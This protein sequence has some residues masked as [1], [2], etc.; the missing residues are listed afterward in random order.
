MQSNRH[1]NCT[2]QMPLMSSIELNTVPRTARSG[3]SVTGQGQVKK[4]D[5]EWYEHEFYYYT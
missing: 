1:N 4:C 2:V 3:V 5:S